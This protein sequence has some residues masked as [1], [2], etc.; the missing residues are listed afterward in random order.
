[1]NV[2]EVECTV[3]DSEPYP[4]H[5]LSRR[6]IEDWGKRV[7]SLRPMSN[8]HPYS[9]LT[10]QIAPPQLPHERNGALAEVRDFTVEVLKVVTNVNDRFGRSKEKLHPWR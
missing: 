2:L 10:A 7:N 6:E 9:A 5:N 3:G 4:V 1:M 8:A